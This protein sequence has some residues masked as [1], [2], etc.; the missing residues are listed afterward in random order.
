MLTNTEHWARASRTRV[1]G[2]IKNYYSRH[3]WLSLAGALDQGR[4][5]SWAHRE[6]AIPWFDFESDKAVSGDPPSLGPRTIT[7]Q[8]Q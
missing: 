2:S 5:T 6:T 7:F 1:I 3:L 4:G 8:V